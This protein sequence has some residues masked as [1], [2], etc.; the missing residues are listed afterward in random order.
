MIEMI[1]VTKVFNDGKNRV[2][3]VKNISL[4]VNQGEI[5]GIIGY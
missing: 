5:Y 1:N 2:E 4:K 3:A